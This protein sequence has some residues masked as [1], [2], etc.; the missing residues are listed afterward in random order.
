[1][2]SNISDINNNLE[3]ILVIGDVFFVQNDI[4][5]LINLVRN[6]L[7]DFTVL[8]NLE[9]SINFANNKS[10][11]LMSLSL[12]MFDPNDMPQNLYFSVVNN[13][14][15]DYGI[16]NFL[17]NIKYLE[18][19]VVYSSNDK[20]VTYINNK[21][22][23]FLADKKEQCV[24]RGTNFLSFSNSVLKKIAPNLKDSHV[25][26]HGGIEYRKNPTLYQRSLARKIIDNGA[27]SVIFHHSHVVGHFEYW[28]EKL[29]HYGL[30]N[31]FFSDTFNLHKL[32]ESISQGVIIDG[33]LKILNLKVLS[34]VGIVDSSY[35]NNS[36]KKKDYDYKQFYKNRYK[37]ESS[38]SP[39]QLFLNGIFI[40][41][42][43]YLWS[44]V[45]NFFVK[46]KLSKPIKSFLNRFIKTNDH[47][48]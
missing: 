34:P 29:I 35:E 11:K 4:Q 30:G 14:V 43:F 38:F 20:V 27:E 13:H 39:R 6:E 31:A 16:D 33:S 42:Q 5:K 32:E 41:T 26:V 12:P 22:F 3:N 17:K 18:N 7:K 48:E 46:N 40:D 9:G 2:N 10:K 24:L 25:I 36:F 21:K 37:L 28:K 1:M 15:T 19:K 8:A 44:T 47:H 45:A 23:I